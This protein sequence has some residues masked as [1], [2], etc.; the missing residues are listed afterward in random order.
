MGVGWHEI[1]SVK[2]ERALHKAHSSLSTS[3]C[4]DPAYRGCDLIGKQ[5][6]E[7]ALERNCNDKLNGKPL[8]KTGYANEK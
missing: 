7:L 1:H 4:N 3:N 6:G 5:R 8:L 2:N